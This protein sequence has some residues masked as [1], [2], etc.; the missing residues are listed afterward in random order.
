MAQRRKP[1]RPNTIAV[2][3]TYIPRRCGIATFTSDLCEALAGEMKR[4][5]RVE[6]LAMD[7]MATGYAYPDRVKFQ[8]QAN[9][10]ADYVKAAEF[11][12]I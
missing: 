8:M 12:K 11:I 5:G 3:G 9:I 4:G 2:I 1:L 7:D 10:Q 6:A